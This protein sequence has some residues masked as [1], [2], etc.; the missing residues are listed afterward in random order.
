LSSTTRLT[1]RILPTWHWQK[2][3]NS[4]RDS[5]N[6]YGALTVMVNNRL[7]I[8]IILMLVN[9]LMSKSKFVVCLNTHTHTHAQCFAAFVRYKK[10][11]LWMQLIWESPRH[12]NNIY[13]YG[14]NRFMGRHFHKRHDRTSQ[15]KTNDQLTTA[16]KRHQEGYSLSQCWYF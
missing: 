2:L 8:F 12:N 9:R 10:I 16:W 11:I 13:V 1:C 7:K 5:M 6:F 3:W 4:S 15:K 14:H